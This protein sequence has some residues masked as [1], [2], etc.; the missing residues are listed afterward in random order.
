M[1]DDVTRQLDALTSPLAAKLLDDCEVM[2]CYAADNGLRI[3]DWIGNALSKIGAKALQLRRDYDAAAAA[4]GPKEGTSAGL[5]ELEQAIGA[6]VRDDLRGLTRIH[7]FL[8]E[9]VA[10]A[11]PRSIR[12]TGSINSVREAVR[13][14]PLIWQM[15]LVAMIFLAGYVWLAGSTA[16]GGG[17]D[18]KLRFVDLLCAAGLGATFYAL[19]TAHS[20]IV[21]GT[22]DP[23]YTLV[24]WTR[25]CL[26]LIAGV[27]VGGVV[28]S[29]I[30]KPMPDDDTRVMLSSSGVALLGGFS[31]DFVN[32]VLKRLV[33]TMLTLVRGETQQIIASREQELKATFAERAARQRIHTASRLT[34]LQQRLAQGKGE[35]AKKLLDDMMG[36]LLDGKADAEG[37]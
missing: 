19:F 26:G 20:F 5:A 24:Y 1:A 8:S 7:G 3:P 6:A 37:S 36:Q 18:L 25:L 15:L 28:F 17:I 12:A 14:V 30:D 33:D 4:D 27:I 21:A 16:E 31:A 32:R 34:E 23:K 9:V 10:P 29:Q 22:Y 11:T 35:E 2:A 13:Q